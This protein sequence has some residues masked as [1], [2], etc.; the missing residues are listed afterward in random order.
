MDNFKPMPKRENI[1]KSL[2]RFNIL[3]FIPKRTIA[4]KY[5]PKRITNVQLYTK[6]YV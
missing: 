1:L 3:K 2:I 4:N 5:I 6:T